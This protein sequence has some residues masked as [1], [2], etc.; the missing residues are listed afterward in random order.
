MIGNWQFGKQ[1]AEPRAGLVLDVDVGLSKPTGHRNKASGLI[2]QHGAY[3]GFQQALSLLPFRS[4]RGGRQQE[5]HGFF[6]WRMAAQK[7]LAQRR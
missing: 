5:R 4:L 6:L 1:Q 3:F 2:G 7:F